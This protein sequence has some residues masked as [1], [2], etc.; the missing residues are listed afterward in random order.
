[1]AKLKLKT[2]L[3]LTSVFSLLIPIVII[4][5]VTIKFT[6]DYILEMASER[7]LHVASSAAKQIENML[8]TPQ[9]NLLS[10]RHTI[11]TLHSNRLMTPAEMMDLVVVMNNE[12]QGFDYFTLVDEQGFVIE[13]RPYIKEYMGLNYSQNKVYQ[14]LKSNPLRTVWSTVYV[15]SL[16]NVA[17]IDLGVKVDD[18]TLIG[19]L[20]VDKFDLVIEELNL[21]NDTIVGITDE[22]G[23]YVA[24][25]DYEKVTQR[26]TDPNVNKPGIQSQGDLIYFGKKVSYAYYKILDFGWNV[27]VY[28]PYDALFAS[29]QEFIMVLLIIMLASFAGVMAV[30]SR[31]NNRILQHFKNMIGNLKD[32]SQGNYKTIATSDIYVEFDTIINEF[33][34]MIYEIKNR[35]EEIVA[36]REEL[37]A[38]NEELEQRVDDRTTK[39]V[40]ANLIFEKTLEDLKATQNQLIE[41]EKLA[42]LG[43]LVAGIAHEINTPI[44]VTMTA[45]TYL[46]EEGKVLE[47]H[48]R[49]DTLSREELQD[50][51][52]VF[53]EGTR[54]IEKNIQ[55]ASE[56]IRSFKMMAV[57]QS[58]ADVREFELGS[59]VK[60]VLF[61]LEPKF[62]KARAELQIDLDEEIML[63][64]NPGDVSQVMTNLV[65]NALIHGVYHKDNGKV[66]IHVS[67][68]KSVAHIDVTD[69]GVGIPEENMHTI[70]EPFFTTK[71]GQ[72]GTGLGL[73]IVHNLVTQKLKGTIR[74]VSEIG[75]GTTFQIRIPLL[76]DPATSQ[77]P[78]IKNFK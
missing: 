18:Y 43:G 76:K 4:S 39:L 62:K 51:F 49:N 57:D 69:N 54:I 55:K 20:K 6:N 8:K 19:A 58:N 25:V 38:M 31:N 13:T 14:A 45:I 32:V 56:L 50:Y 64:A 21:K 73:N 71:R 17:T 37:F 44:G 70:F 22:T 65:M 40:R 5:L 77:T 74:C 12:S 10:T 3:N 36:Q 52:E 53:S 30:S 68:H 48:Y 78:L 66:T 42:S 75:V 61:S 29:R 2:A 41:S 33:N 46:M 9:E 59:Y 47:Q 63:Y 26:V 28:E 11:E 1:M 15:S 23:I 60:D 7:N 67:Q 24:H 34:R 72:G 16:H 35:E 27:V